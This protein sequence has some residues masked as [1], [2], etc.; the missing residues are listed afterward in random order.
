[1]LLTPIKQVSCWFFQDYS[2]NGT[3][4][5]PIDKGIAMCTACPESFSIKDKNISMAQ[6]C[7]YRKQR[8]ATRLKMIQ[9]YT[10]IF[11]AAFKFL[12]LFTKL[13]YTT[14]VACN[15][16]WSRKSAIQIKKEKGMF[17]FAPIN[18]IKC[19]IRQLS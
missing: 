15:I 9:Q 1:M 18:I 10:V 14:I 3:G 17:P 2:T 7:V 13:S 6:N 5:I 16:F 11:M 19:D 8:E 4:V 12:A